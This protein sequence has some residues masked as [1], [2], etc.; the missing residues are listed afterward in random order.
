M[1]PDWREPTTEVLPELT[2]MQRRR[3]ARRLE[4][5]GAEIAVIMARWQ[6]VLDRVEELE[7]RGLAS[8][9]GHATG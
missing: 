1:F 9:S 3:T 6:P 7:A 4:N 8:W 5:L 2:E